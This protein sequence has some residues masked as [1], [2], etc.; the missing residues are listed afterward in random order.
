MD[1]IDTATAKLAAEMQLADVNA[2]L[3]GMEQEDTDEH[4]AFKAMQLSFQDVIQVYESRL[5]VMNVLGLEHAP[6]V[7]FQRL[8][9]QERQARDDHDLARRLSGLP[10]QQHHSTSPE[11]IDL[12]KDGIDSDEE[13]NAPDSTLGS[14]EPSSFPYDD[15][16][17][18]PRGGIVIRTPRARSPVPCVASSSKGKGKRKA[19]SID[20]EDRNNDRPTH[21][22]CSACMERFPRFDL[23]ELTCKRE[24]DLAHHAY[25][26]DCLLDLFKSSL[27][28]TTLFPPRCCGMTI[29]ISDTARFFPPEL[30]SQYEEKEVELRTPNATYC[31][32]RACVIFIKPQY[33]EADVATCPVCSTQ[34]CATCKNPS[35]KGLCPEDPTVQ[36]LMQVAKEKKWQRCYNCRTLVE[37]VHGCYH[38][39]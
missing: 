15:L 35:H 6:R 17:R 14:A 21:G 8:V 24:G 13:K 5:A 32:K 19:D 4:V 36:Q 20:L 39:R 30:I 38:M 27:T 12:T 11:I 10:S 22:P 2:I 23:L 34:T 18:P 33:V 37:L 25:C 3:E 26:R 1:G 31:S 7:Q 16:P 29:S 9:E 28:D